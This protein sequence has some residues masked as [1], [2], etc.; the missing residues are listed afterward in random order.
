MNDVTAT[1]GGTRMTRPITAG[2]DGSQESLAALA[3]AAREAV[4]RGAPLHVVQ[5]WRFQGQGVAGT[6]ERETQ[7]GWARDAL[8]EAVGT[9][10]EQHPGLTVTTDLREGDAVAAL[11][12][13]A[14]DAETLVLGSRGHGPVVG[15]LLGSVGQ[16]VIA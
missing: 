1:Q 9:V 11:L 8:A 12:A 6:V 3:W 13:A 2:L 14:A 7:E 4:R 5:A 15:F 10:T 16:Q